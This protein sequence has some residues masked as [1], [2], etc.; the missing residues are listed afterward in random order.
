MKIVFLLPLFLLL[1]SC[2]K[3]NGNE[4]IIDKTEKQDL[5]ITAGEQNDTVKYLDFNPDIIVQIKEVSCKSYYGCD[6]IDFD[7]DSKYDF[8]INYSVV[9]PDLDYSCGCSGDCFPSGYQ[10]IELIRLN[11]KY[12]ISI[13]SGRIIHQFSFN[14]KISENNKWDTSANSYFANATF[15]NFMYKWSNVDNKYIGIRFID[16]DTIYGWIRI[17]CHDTI[18]IKDCGLKIKK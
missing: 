4:N 7:N 1:F 8:K 11:T 18:T 15:P 6:S 5:S 16:K 13:D 9:Y 2:K 3:N 10:D 17:S 12:Q 14:D